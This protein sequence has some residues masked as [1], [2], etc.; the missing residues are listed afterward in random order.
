MTKIGK[1]CAACIITFIMVITGCKN[2]SNFTEI[3]FDG[4]NIFR[5]NPELLTLINKTCR[6]KEHIKLTVGFLIDD[7]IFIK[8]FDVNG[9]I[10]LEHYVYEIGSITKT[11]TGS[12]LA[13]YIHDGK[14]S[15]D[16]GIQKYI[17]GLNENNYYPTIRRLMT[18]TAGYSQRFP[19]NRSEFFNLIKEFPFGGKRLN[20]FYHNLNDIINLT[21]SVNLKDRDYNYTYSNFGIS[22]PGHA[23]GIISGKGYWDTKND[24][25]KN[26]LGLQN[27]YLGISERNIS[28]YN[29]RNENC[30]NWLWDNDNILA[31]AGA[32]SS[33]AYDLLTYARMHINE[34]RPYLSL[35]HQNQTRGGRNFDMGLGWML[36]R[37]NNNI[38]FHL[39]GT[40]CFSTYLVIDKERK[41]ASVVLS[42]YRLFG[43][44]SEERLALSA[45]EYLQN[46]NIRNKIDSGS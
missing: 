17:T 3:S 9:E 7:N 21:E 18:H 10:D 44:Y 23:I 6:N 35:S 40:G 11:F 45:L 37:K 38:L 22:L 4:D 16:D 42:N 1:I 20:P 30:G 2:S 28:G 32:I 36:N 8:I 24:F 43:I 12:L 25:I 26:E 46:I 29:N 19:L 5:L 39:G 41:V 31:P 15:L 27:T 33:T 13:K 34:E 14:I